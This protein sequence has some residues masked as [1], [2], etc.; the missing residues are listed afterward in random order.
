MPLRVPKE[1][2]EYVK[3]LLELP[4]T[5]IAR[6]LEALK[7][8]GAQYNIYDFSETVSERVGLPKDLVLG[9]SQVL[10]GLYLTKDAQQAPTEAFVDQ[11]VS[12]AFKRAGAFSKEQPEAQ[13]TKVRNFLVAALSLEDTVGTAAKAGFILTQHERI[14]VGAR[15]LTDI[16]PI[17]HVDVSEQPREAVIVHMLRLIYRDS[18]AR[19]F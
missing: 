10:A 9:L 17:F 2:I 4:D 5:E 15:I 7:S 16:R 12:V 13:W 3:R 6:F 14:F 18:E 19:R 11:E 8:A 1:Q